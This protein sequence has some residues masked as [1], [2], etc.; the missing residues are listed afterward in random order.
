MGARGRPKNMTP[1]PR[2]CL[3]RG[4]ALFP[5]L[6][7]EAAVPA[8]WQRGAMP[9]RHAVPAFLGGWHSR[10]YNDNGA[11]VEMLAD[12]LARKKGDAPGLL[13]PMQAA[14][15][16]F[17]PCRFIPGKTRSRPRCWSIA[18]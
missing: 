14:T 7:A 2:C 12:V 18:S 4:H 3:E 6:V 9:K 11:G 10:L 16:L 13:A 1:L 5:L 15:V 8:A 17:S